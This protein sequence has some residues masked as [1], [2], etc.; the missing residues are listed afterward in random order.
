[1][2]LQ[3]QKQISSYIYRNKL[4]DADK[5]IVYNLQYSMEVQSLLY[6]FLFYVDKTIYEKIDIISMMNW[7]N[8]LMLANPQIFLPR[9]IQK[10]L[11]PS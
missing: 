4:T 1:M 10:L 11:R 2:A 5:L 9:P 3:H 6:L 8:N 7:D